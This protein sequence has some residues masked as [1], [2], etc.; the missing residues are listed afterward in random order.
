MNKKIIIIGIM[1]VLFISSIMMNVQAF[2]NTNKI[3]HRG[4]FQAE[5]GVRSRDTDFSLEGNYRDFPRG[6]LLFGTIG[7]VDSER[8]LRFQGFCTR[9]VFIIQTGVRNNIVN[10]VG[11][12]N[13]YNEDLNEYS[14]NWRGFI[15]GLGRTNGWI[16]AS[17]SS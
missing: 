16:T 8:T 11:R 2:S 17:F 13:D 3:F 15:I 14:G 7:P 1:A 6:H 5:I 12:F 9:N 10:I 4:S